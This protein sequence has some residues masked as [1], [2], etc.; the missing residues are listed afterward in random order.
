MQTDSLSQAY[1]H[2]KSGHFDAA[3]ERACDLLDANPAHAE[4]NHLLGAIR[5][6]QGR[7]EES[8][9]FL[10]RAAASPRATAELHN[11]LGAVLSKLGRKDEA[12]AAFERALAMNPAYAD[13]LNNLGVIYLETQKPEQAVSAFR[14]AVVLEPGLLHATANL[15]ATYQGV[16]PSWHFAMMDDHKR[17]GAY[18]AAIRRAAP[19]K[20]VLDIGT[21][22][23]LLALM[24][25]RAGASKV[26]TCEAV[27]LIAERAREIIV[28]N[29]L[30]DR[31]GVVPLKST[32]MSVPGIM[33]ER[34]EVLVT[35]TFASG[36]ITEGV[37]PA[38]EHAHEYL[39]VPDAAI[40]PA[41]ASIMG[42]LAGGETLQGM[43]F[44]G[45]I[46]G[47]DLS[48]FNDFAPAMLA[49]A[50]GNI[51]HRVL[52]G[53]VE[54]MRFDFREKRFPM[55]GVRLALKATQHGICVGVAQWIRLE[56]D[57]HATYENRPSP[58][59]PFN[60]H[61][62]HILHRFPRPVTVAPGD[63]VPVLFR[64]DRSQI[65][66]DLID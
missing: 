22:A 55:G 58:N 28:R 45:R 30:S 43:L 29:G 4:A 26:T 39:L 52:S 18:E 47:F 38:I 41:A 56:L 62:T 1:E 21:G 50:L 19:G 31:I 42:Y 63:V 61:W 32:A 35:E 9:A 27:S 20:R 51:P 33:P 25:A 36:L 53:D 60:G 15:R 17:N 23:G 6:Q 11:N 48:G 7:I 64:H 37:L 34:A 16:V 3:E 46:A 59:A 2:F 24:A 65:G 49:V 14:K 66:I 54:V 40:I 44:A 10:K 12:V 8:L 5:F 13:A 57:A